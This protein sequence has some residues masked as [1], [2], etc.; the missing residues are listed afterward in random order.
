MHKDWKNRNEYLVNEAKENKTYSE[1]WEK[2][3]LENRK[4]ELNKSNWY[5]T[6]SLNLCQKNYD[7]ENYKTVIDFGLD[8]LKKIDKK[9]RQYELIES[10]VKD[11]KS[12]FHR[13]SKKE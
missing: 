12:N 7:L 11:A 9:H 10:Y 2:T 13:R 6:I 1:S 5:K 3:F 4:E 8:A